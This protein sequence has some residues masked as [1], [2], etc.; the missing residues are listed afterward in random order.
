MSFILRRHAREV[1]VAAAI[2]SLMILLLLV[3]PS[4]FSGENL[5]DVFFV[6]AP[7]MIIAVGMTL[8]VLTGQ[9][10]IS[11]GSNFAICSVL[12]GMAA[13]W[14]LPGPVSGL[15]A[16]LAGASIGALNGCLVAY[17]GV[18]SIVVTLATMVAFRDGLRWLTQGAWIG[19]LPGHFQWLGLG[20]SAFTVLTFALVLLLILSVTWALRFLAPARAVYAVGSNSQ[21]ARIIGIDIER[22]VFMVFAITGALT[23]LAAGLNSLR[24]KQIPSNS[25]LGLEMNVIAAVAVGGAAITGGAGTI[26]GTVLGVVLLGSIG[27]ALTFLGVSPYWEKAIQG[28]IIL[29]AIA[30]NLSGRRE[31]NV[32]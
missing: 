17:V 26:A 28:A 32:G 25:G 3:A 6:N 2:V 9:I 22:V 18:P 16:C 14:G 23:G 12:T 5:T 24:F 21:A 19:D 4:Y 30:V 27:T 11:V 1:S 31:S 10:D 13:R 8:I 20:Q 29:T 15:V 7:V